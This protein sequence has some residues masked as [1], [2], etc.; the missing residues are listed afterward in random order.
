VPIK[1]TALVIG[2]AAYTGIPQL[3]NPVNDAEDMSVKLV[4]LGFE[5]QAL[6]NATIENMRN[7]LV[8]FGNSLEASSVGLLFF[9]GHAFQ[10]DGKNYLAAIDTIASQPLQVQLSALDLDFVLGTM[11]NGSARTGLVILDSCRNNP[12]EGRT[13]SSASNELAPVYAPKGTLIAFSTSPGQTSLDGTGRN[14]YYTQ[15]LL[16]HIDT[17]NLLIETMFKRVR[18]TLEDLTGGRQTSW[19]HTSLTGDFR[20]QLTAVPGAHGYGPMSTADSLFPRNGRSS[21]KLIEALKSYNWYTQNPAIDKFTTEQARGC[22][23]DEL[24]VVGRNIYQAACGGSNSAVSFLANFKARTLDLTVDQRKAVL[25]GLLYEIFFDS[26]GQH[27]AAPKIQ[28]FDDAF[29]LQEDQDLG[30]SFE[31]IKGCLRPYADHYFALPGSGDTVTVSVD[32]EPP[33]ADETLTLRAV[34]LDSSNILGSQP[35]EEELEFGWTR[36]RVFDLP[37]FRGYLSEQMVVPRRLLTVDFLFPYTSGTRLILPPTR[38]IGRPDPR[39][40]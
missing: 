39:T 4:A 20:F 9:A 1:L 19:E 24:F 35:E 8:E 29:E 21:G 12:F 32:C 27:R 2:N 37:E 25:D 18:S 14:G 33:S 15:A 11:R 5:V 13:R 34:W 7:A 16:R 17:P 36:E 23:M 30:S 10:I 38:T 40:P 28:R 26:D 22:S 31:F 6:L 3:A